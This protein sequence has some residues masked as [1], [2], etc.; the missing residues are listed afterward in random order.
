MSAIHPGITADVSCRLLEVDFSGI[1]AVLTGYYLYRHE[2]DPVGAPLYIRMARLGI[3]AGVAGV[4]AGEPV[5]WS[6]SDDDCRKQIKHIKSTFPDLYDPAKRTV[7]ANNFGM[8]THGM[9]EKFPKFFPTIKHAEKFQDHYYQLAP[10]LPKWHLALRQHAHKHGW[11]GGV[12]LE[13]SAPSIWTHPYGYRHAF[14][15]VLSLKPVN[16]FTARKWLR[17]PRRAWRIQSLHGRWFASGMG[18]DANRVIAFYPQS[19]A[20]GR[21]K[22]AQLRLFL[23]DSPDYIGDAYFGRTPLLVPIH[24]SLLLHVPNRAWDRVVETVIRVMQD[25]SERLPI[26]AAWG[27]G[28]S[29]PIGISAKAGKNWAPKDA[30]NADGMTEIPVPLWAYSPPDDP[31]LPREGEG[32]FDDWKALERTVA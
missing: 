10:G 30:G 28:P 7:H 5:D 21:L 11:L 14:W 19:T 13:G 8:T 29:L 23:P 15:D 2:I 32:E 12:A 4:A 16:E 6:A 25:P 27:W 31:V 18:G 20:A 1:E 26:P 9:V 22:E 3:H 17:D 24:D